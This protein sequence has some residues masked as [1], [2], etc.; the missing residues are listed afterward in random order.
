LAERK[1]PL[2]E[3]ANQT[4]ELLSVNRGDK[5]NMIIVTQEGV[6]LFT[7]EQKQ[8]ARGKLN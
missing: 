6:F 2:E 1:P 4:L 5:R 3:K 8:P 7:G